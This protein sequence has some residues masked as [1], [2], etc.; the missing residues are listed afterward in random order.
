[1][2]SSL[3][4]AAVIVV[5][6]DYHH[7]RCP[8]HCCYPLLPCHCQTSS[9]SPI[10]S[11]P[12][13]HFPSPSP[14][15]TQSSSSTATAVA[16]V[17][18]HHQTPMPPL[19]TIAAVISLVAGHLHHQSLTAAHRLYCCQPQPTGT[20]LVDGWLLFVSIA[21]HLIHLLPLCDSWWS[22]CWPL[23]LL[24]IECF[25]QALLLPVTAHL[26]LSW[27]LLV[28]ASSAKERQHHHHY[29]HQLTKGSTIVKAFICS[30][31]LDLFLTYLQYFGG[32][33]SCQVGEF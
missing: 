5:V 31:S 20:V 11:P 15:Q 17:H 2:P 18:R 1:M 33:R 32:R 8:L 9:L 7:C 29:H 24:I 3:F 4:I 22:C 13:C 23:L 14:S 26:C 19:L 25:P 21:P 30:D 27:Q 12:P 28:V 6:H 16:A 10:V